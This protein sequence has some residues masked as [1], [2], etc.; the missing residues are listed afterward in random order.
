VVAVKRVRERR[1]EY[2]AEPENARRSHIERER[3]RV[4]REAAE[5]AARGGARHKPEAGGMPGELASLFSPGMKHVR[6]LKEWVAVAK[7][8]DRESGAGGPVDLDNGVA[9][10][11]R[12]DQQRD[13]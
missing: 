6:E 9:A 13:Y 11:A 1:A 8:D 3:A 12:E 7:M 4:E 5:D 10:L 2:L